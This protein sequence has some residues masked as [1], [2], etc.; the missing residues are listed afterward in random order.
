M[1]TRINDR[2]CYAAIIRVASALH[3]LQPDAPRMGVSLP[4]DRPWSKDLAGFAETLGVPLRYWAREGCDD[5][6]R[7]GLDRIA[8][9]YG[10]G[11]RPFVCSAG[12]T[13]HDSI[14]WWQPSA[15]LGP[16]AVTRREFCNILGAVEATA[17]EGGF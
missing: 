10:G 7:M 2:D 16:G 6:P 1:T 17:R 11:V 12:Q 8:G 15:G 5:G 13:G 3:T 9:C 4:M 14:R